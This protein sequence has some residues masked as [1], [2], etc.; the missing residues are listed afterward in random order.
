MSQKVVIV[1]G[2]LA[3]SEAALYLANSGMKVDL[4]EMRPEKKTPVHKTNYL[5]ELVCSNSL[6]SSSFENASGVLKEEITHLGSVLIPLVKK[7]SVP[8]GGALAT[9]RDLFAAHV[10]DMIEK[11]PNINLKHEHVHDIHVYSDAGDVVLV[12][13]GPL[14]TDELASDI[15]KY[16]GQEYLHFYDAVAP[17]VEFDSI[18]MSKAYMMDRYNKTGDSSYVNCPMNEQEYDIFY[19]YLI[20]A[21]TIELK[22][23]EKEASFF[24]GCMP[25][26]VI[27]RRGKDTLR[28]GP[29]KP[30][31]LPDPNT[32][33]IPYAVVQLRQDNAAASLFNLV[34]F[35]TNLKWT[36]QKDLLSLIPGL[37]KVNI[38]RFGVMHRNTYINSPEFL[39]PTLEAKNYPGLF[40][41]GQ[42]TGVEG[43]TESI[44]TGLFAAINIKRFMRSESLI[45]LD[46]KTVL[47][48]LCHYITT[49]EKKYFQ[50]M[51]AN[52]GIMPPLETQKKIRDKKLRKLMYGER[53]LTCLDSFLSQSV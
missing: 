30:V 16:T 25:V 7:F 40:F 47:G 37:E 35:Q 45:V 53:A 19:N 4:Y 9:D 43:Y 41:A 52:W 3:G 46:N 15:L 22:G 2:G 31:G 27:A 21:P 17:I 23:F 14:T 29:M 5:A 49:A 42:L 51:N 28:Y 18:D 34:G 26:E 6:G 48:S 13:S 11:H 44:A 10:T 50:P 38:V 20:N 8:A 33:Q 12:A 24:E 36:A 1:G 39:N 32:D